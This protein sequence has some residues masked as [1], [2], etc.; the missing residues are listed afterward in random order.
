MAGFVQLIGFPYK[1]DLRKSLFDEQSQTVEREAFRLLRCIN[2]LGEIDIN[3]AST[4][5][6]NL[7]ISERKAGHDFVKTFDNIRY[8]SVNMG[9]KEQIKDWGL[10]NWQALFFSLKE[11]YGT[12][13]LL[14]IGS[15]SDFEE[16]QRLLD[17]WPGK[18]INAC[19]KLSPRLSAAALEKSIL[20]IGHD[21]GPFHL[22]SAQGLPAIG[23]YGNYNPPNLWHPYSHLS[24]V[25]HNMHGVSAISVKEVRSKIDSILNSLI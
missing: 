9:G 6:L 19:G 24:E 25:I 4:W 3:K 22:A 7:S 14:A 16:A 5:D 15:S 17:G 23:L 1:K 18:T 13:G 8:F 20:F 21:S 11:K 12:Y 10:A 2:K